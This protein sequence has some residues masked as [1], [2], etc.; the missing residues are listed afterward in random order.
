MLCQCDGFLDYEFAIY[1]DRAVWRRFR[2]RDQQRYSCAHSQQGKYNNRDEFVEAVIAA[3]NDP[4]RLREIQTANP[5]EWEAM[6]R[7]QSNEMEALGAPTVIGL[8]G[9]S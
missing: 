8:D 6:L 9:R 3:A 2:S 7:Q 4:Y 1:L 5:A